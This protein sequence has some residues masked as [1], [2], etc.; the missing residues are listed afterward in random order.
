MNLA[1]PILSDNAERNPAPPERVNELGRR[2]SLAR[3]IF[4]AALDRARVTLFDDPGNWRAGDVAPV[5]PPRPKV[6]RHPPKRDRAP[7]T[8]IHGGWFCHV[9]HSSYREY[10]AEKRR[11]KFYVVR[12]CDVCRKARGQYKAVT[13]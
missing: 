8:L 6:V 4:G 3:R 12:V 2:Y 9:G 13:Q 1:F 7:T 10:R 11:G 5:A